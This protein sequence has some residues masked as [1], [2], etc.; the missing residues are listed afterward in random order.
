MSNTIPFPL[1]CNECKSSY[2]LGS[3]EEPYCGVCG[4][5]AINDVRKKAKKTLTITEEQAN[6]IMR[7]VDQVKL[8]LRKE[9]DL[10]MR[11][12]Q[13]QDFIPVLNLVL[14]IATILFE[15]GL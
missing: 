3:N 6:E 13:K 1:T 10:P 7:N 8:F 15:N 14:V 9:R 2:I 11:D 4:S 12:V 5:Y